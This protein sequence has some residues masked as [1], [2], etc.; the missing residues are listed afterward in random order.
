MITLSGGQIAHESPL[1]REFWCCQGWAE[2]TEGCYKVA[3]IID[4][5]M[6]ESFPI[7]E[8]SKHYT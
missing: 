3:R 4:G 1:S 5:G 2:V 7:A 6:R 8:S